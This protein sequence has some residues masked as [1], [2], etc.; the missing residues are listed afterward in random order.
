[1]NL[2]REDAQEN[3]IKD[4]LKEYDQKILKQC[5][6]YSL[7]TSLEVS[8]TT[9]LVSRAFNFTVLKW[10]FILKSKFMINVSLTY[11]SY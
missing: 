2:L 7:R 1:M 10:I 3:V 9:I 4:V 6:K 5:F 8:K 11:P